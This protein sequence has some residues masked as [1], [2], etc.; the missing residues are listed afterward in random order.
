MF[1]YYFSME[2]TAIAYRRYMPHPAMLARSAFVRAMRDRAMEFTASVSSDRKDASRGRTET[3][4]LSALPPTLAAQ[5]RGLIESYHDIH[6]YA[7]LPNML[8]RAEL[9]DFIKAHPCLRQILRKASTTRSAKVSNKGF[10]EIATAILSLE[11]LASDFAS[12][13]T[14]FPEARSTANTLLRTRSSRMFLTEYYLYP[15]KQIN[16]ATLAALTPPS[17][18]QSA[19]PPWHDALSPEL[20]SQKQ[21]LNYTNARQDELKRESALVMPTTA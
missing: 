8:W 2:V 16:P 15:P 18:G 1:G 13:S 6:G 14:M 9:G 19:E 10:V 17:Q 21:A 4:D 11:I 12:W 20:M 3:L 5:C 7:C